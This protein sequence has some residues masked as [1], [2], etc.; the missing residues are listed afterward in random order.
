MTTV[1]SPGRVNLIGEH[2]DYTGGLV[3]PLAIHLG[4]T[5]TGTAGGDRLAIDSDGHDRLDL[6]LDVA[7]GCALDEIDPAWGRFVVAVARRLG[8][9]PAATGTITS[10][11]PIGGT[12]LSSSTALSCVAALLYG[13]GLSHQT[14]DRLELA[15]LVRAA[16]VDVTGVEIGLMDQAACLAATDGNALLMDCR[17][18]TVDQVPLPDSVEVLIVHSG[19]A[20][21]LVDSE[22]ADR[23]AACEAIEALIG[24]LRD[25]D[26]DAVAE[27]D[28][29]V[30]RR[31]ARH[32]VTE[33]ARVRSMIDALAAD[34]PRRA[35]PAVPHGAHR[36][37]PGPGGR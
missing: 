5:F 33:N 36:A 15:K 25:A 30:L 7:T 14:G 9:S 31:R 23:R 29:A 32:V 18:V 8:A 37:P 26:L 3:L 28:D 22:Y 17:A 12:G 24:P 16:E 35:P 4:V 21:E 34:A 1:F 27:L 2:T 6:P 11:L 10:S 13:T 20:R 19:H